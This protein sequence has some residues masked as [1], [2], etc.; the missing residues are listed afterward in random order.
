MSARQRVIRVCSHMLKPPP[1][2]VI[3]TVY[4][5]FDKRCARGL[6]VCGVVSQRLSGRSAC[7]TT[8]GCSTSSSCG[9]KSEMATGTRSCKSSSG[10]RVIGSVWENGAGMQVVHQAIGQ[11]RQNHSLMMGKITADDDFRFVRRQ[12]ARRVVERF[13]KSPIPKRS[14]RRKR[15]KIEHRIARPRGKRQTRGIGGDDVIPRQSAL[16]AQPRHTEGLILIRLSG[17]E[18]GECRFRHAPGDALLPA[19]LHLPLDCRIA[20]LS[21]QSLRIGSQKQTRH[22]VLEH[23]AAPREEPGSGRRVRQ[24]TPEMEPMPVVDFAFANRQKAGQ[25][26]FGRE[27]VVTA[28]I[29]LS[30]AQVVAD[31]E[32]PA[33]MVVKECEIHVHSQFVQP[34]GKLIASSQQFFRSRRARYDGGLQLLYNRQLGDS[35]AV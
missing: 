4:W 20:T 17:V 8:G 32:Q 30:A 6:N 5:P 29:Q 14:F 34:L 33:R 18:H 28:A 23:R 24:R 13:I 22:Q 10:A 31:G 26:G 16:Q 2:L 15:T 27:Q 3:I 9:S 25:P 1:A 21:E 35:I 12:A 11:R 7:R 19:E